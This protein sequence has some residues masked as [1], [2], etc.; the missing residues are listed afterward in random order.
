MLAVFSMLILSWLALLDA[1]VGQRSFHANDI[2]W[3]VA[4][5]WAKR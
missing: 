3:V 2:P 4:V 1:Q 5:N